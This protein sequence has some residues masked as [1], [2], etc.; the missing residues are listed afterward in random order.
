MG[1][2]DYQQGERDGA[3]GVYK[4]PFGIIDELFGTGDYARDSARRNAD[5]DNGYRNGKKN[6][7][8]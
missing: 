6:P 7:K 8:K 2:K 1:E 4:K 3:R 5:Y